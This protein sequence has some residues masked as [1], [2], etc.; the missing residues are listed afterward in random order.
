ML[1]NFKQRRVFENIQC[2]N[3][4]REPYICEYKNDSS[5]FPEYEQEAWNIAAFYILEHNVMAI[6]AALLQGRTFNIEAPYYM[7]FGMAGSIFGHEITHGFDSTGS[8][9]GFNGRCVPIN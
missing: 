8:L 6:C 3:E 4:D 2:L 7:N 5:P 1:E 9:F